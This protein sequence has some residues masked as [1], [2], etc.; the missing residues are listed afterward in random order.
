ME[1]SEPHHVRG[2]N[3]C[4]VWLAQGGGLGNIP[5]APGTFGTLI[6]IPLW[7]L[8]IISGQPLV[9]FC[10]MALGFTLSVA[11]SG[12][13][14]KILKRHDPGCVVIDEYT[15]LPCC[16]V[17]WHIL[18]WVRTGDWPGPEILKE[19]T[20]WLWVGLGFLLFRLFDALKPWPISL[21]QRFYGGWGVTLDDYAA[22]LAVNMVLLILMLTF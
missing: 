11:I 2:M 12:K 20:T 18:T 19:G 13:A 17:G 1:S 5:F 3:R 15:A 10:A 22:A 9:F 6:G 14:E 7:C 16:Y 8:W 21:F 4:I